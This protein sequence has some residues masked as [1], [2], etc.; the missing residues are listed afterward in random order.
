MGKYIQVFTTT[1]NRKDAEKIAKKLLE[2]KLAACVQIFPVS[3]IYRWKGRIDRSREY[4]CIIKS[5]RGLYKK[6]EETIKEIHPYEVPE[7]ISFP[8]SSGSKDYLEWLAEE[9]E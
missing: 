5:K 2:N 9:T 7:I 8:I 1:G 6:I 4:L 3:S